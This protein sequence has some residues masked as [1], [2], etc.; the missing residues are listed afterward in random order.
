MEFW[1]P[2]PKH[3]TREDPGIFQDLSDQDLCDQDL[4]DQ[5]FSDQGLSRILKIFQSRRQMKFW[6]PGPK[7]KTREDPGIIQ[8]LSDKDLCDQ[9]LSDQD[10]SR[11]YLEF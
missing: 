7:H 10:L 1:Q 8:D 11:I 5:D 9:D 6:Q 3:K 2:G 4:C